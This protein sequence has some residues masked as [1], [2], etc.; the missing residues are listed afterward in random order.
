MLMVK[1]K[2][3]HTTIDDGGACKWP[4]T[5]GRP[6][7]EG[8]CW[9]VI[10]S[11]VRQADEAI[12]AM[13]REQYPTYYPQMR[14]MKTPRRDQVAPNKRDQL[15][16]LARPVLVPL[17][18]GYIFIHFDLKTGRWHELF[19]IYGVTGMYITAGLPAAIDEQK[20]T[21]IRALEVG[22]AIPLA[23]PVEQLLVAI[24]DEVK[25]EEG[26]FA[27]FSGTVQELDESKRRVLL[28]LLVFG[29]L[30]PVPFSFDQVSVSKKSG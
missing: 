5:T 16:S 14:I 21:R 8:P 18:A 28:E 4:R 13:D 3:D 25:V 19:D 17:F 23:T 27:G 2:Q 26:P 30:R 1:A 20:I 29:A 10:H 9:H 7:I 24:G 6:P 15:Q 11:D 22:G 12:R